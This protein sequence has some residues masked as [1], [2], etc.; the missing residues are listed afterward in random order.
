MKQE[1]QKDLQSKMIEMLKSYD[2][3][4]QRMNKVIKGLKAY[5]K[6]LTEP[7]HKYLHEVFDKVLFNALCNLDLITELKYLDMS[8]VVGNVFGTNFFARITAHSCFEILDNL[9][10]TV[11]KEIVELIENRLGA[12]ALIELN[13]HVKELNS[14]K[15]QHVNSLKKIRTNLFG[16]RMNAGREQAEQMLQINPKSI[17]DIGN[18][19]FK[20]QLNIQ[21]TFM[22]KVL[23]KI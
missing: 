23:S 15:K 7:E 4:I 17:Y 3:V 22:M 9:N 21:D 11:G 13:A 2:L 8:N 1:N 20:I 10:R 14:I 6:I 5:P 12:E 16:H 19:I 18:R